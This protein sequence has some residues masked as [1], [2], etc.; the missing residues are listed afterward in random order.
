MK[1]W[2]YLELG[3][4]RPPELICFDHLYSE[5][6][7][8]KLDIKDA[9]A[10][11]F[12]EDLAMK[13][14]NAEEAPAAPGEDWQGKGLK[15]GALA[16]DDLYYFELILADAVPVEKLRTKI[17]RLRSDFRSIAGSQEFSEYLGSKPPDLQSPPEPPDPKDKTTSREDAVHYEKLLREDLKDLLGR[18]YM[19]YAVLPVR[20]KRL[21]DLTLFAARLCLIS[22]ILLLG[23]LL[24][25]FI[26][27]LVSEVSTK[28]TWAEMVETFVNS[29]TLASLTVFV[30][31]VSGA[32][33]GFVSALQRIQ[34]PRTEGDSL[35]NL[36]LL[37]H[38]SKSVFVAPITG[39][40][41]ATLLY[42]MFAAGILQGTFFPFI[43]TPGS[44][45]D[46]AG[47]RSGTRRGQGEANANNTARVRPPE[48]EANNADSPPEP[49]D[50]PNSK[51][52]GNSSAEEAPANTNANAGNSNAE[53]KR[54]AEASP[55]SN[56][57][58]N[59]G[60]A[61]PSDQQKK[62]DADTVREPTKGL[63]VFDFLA[64]SGPGTG[65]DYALLI[66]WCFIAGFAERFV[67]D[68]LDRLIANSKSNGKK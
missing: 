37:F 66:I 56:T 11:Q 61:D 68:A 25:V 6:L 47:M 18:M 64:R 21:T 60:A 12:I 54:P 20:E 43:F 38:G 46:Q 14:K 19:K 29:P 45:Y 32:M 15:P 31:V 48:S 39:A 34:S 62:Q 65:K 7:A 58:S 16:W 30:V 63:N 17:V 24:L 28:T 67:P 57:S 2:K 5:Y 9:S 26:V 35:Y 10:V 51:V 50:Q 40:I 1:F 22:L 36:S 44:R 49:G 4:L 41:F 59:K 23:I 55:K 13:V 33:G 27:P 8:M 53:K 3:S 42:L 52:S